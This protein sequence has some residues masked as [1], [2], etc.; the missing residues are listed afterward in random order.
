MRKIFP[1][2]E[3]EIFK[4]PINLSL[5]GEYTQAVPVRGS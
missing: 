1:F 3:L 5:I 2:W 4:M